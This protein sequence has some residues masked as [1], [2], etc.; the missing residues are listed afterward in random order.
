[1][2]EPLTSSPSDKGLMFL[3]QLVS[4]VNKWENL[5]S[6]N[7]RLSKETFL[8]LNHTT[9]AFIEIVNHCTK[10]FKK[11]YILLGKIQTDKLESRFGQYRSMAGDQYHISVRQIYETESKLRLCHELKLASHKKG[12]ITV[13]I[14]DNSEKNDEEKQPIDLI[15]CDI[16]VEESDIEKIADTLPIVTYLA[17][18]C[19]HAALKKTKC[20]YCLQKLITDKESISHDNYK[21]IDVKDRGGLLYPSKIVVNAV[22]HTYIVVQKLIS[23]KYEDKFIQVLNQRSLVVNLVEDILVTKDIFLSFDVCV[24]GHDILHL[25]SII[26]R[27]A[28][29]SLLNNY[30]KVKNDKLKKIPN[31]TVVSKNKRKL[32][33]FSKNSLSDKGESSKKSNKLKG[34]TMPSIAEVSEK[35]SVNDEGEAGE[36]QNSILTN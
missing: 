2:C 15:F 25:I 9:Q 7:G 35:N 3:K 17:G 33:T 32:E 6:N 36:K 13:D 22:I 11:E 34:G 1:M 28:T 30:C 31:V 8:A 16:M 23:E 20:S 4:W 18:Y 5:D 26:L 10:S 12:S 29:N 21:L 19:S 27:S 14:F 24:D